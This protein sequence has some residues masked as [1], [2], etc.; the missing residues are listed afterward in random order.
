MSIG[1]ADVRKRGGVAHL[2]DGGRTSFYNVHYYKFPILAWL[3][4]LPGFSCAE[5]GSIDIC[6]LSEFDPFW[7]D[8]EWSAVLNPE[9]FL[10]R[11][12]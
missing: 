4:L 1:T 7:D 5:Q 12:P 2:G 8:D 3:D 11:I 9:A 10:L 6:Y